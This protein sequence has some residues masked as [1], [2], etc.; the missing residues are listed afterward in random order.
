MI[1]Y[2]CWLIFGASIAL[3][4]FNQDYE[5]REVC[6]RSL[7]AIQTPLLRNILRAFLVLWL[8]HLIPVAMIYHI[9]AAMVKA[10]K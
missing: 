10:I 5:V 9:I 1:Y 8:M 6:A 3:F 4:E 2:L 7:D